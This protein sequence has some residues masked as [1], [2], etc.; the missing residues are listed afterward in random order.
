[1]GL[2]SSCMQQKSIVASLDL[3]VD[4][5]SSND[6]LEDS[7]VITADIKDDVTKSYYPLLVIPVTSSTRLTSPSTNI[8]S[9]LS[10]NSTTPYLSASSLNIPRERSLSARSLSSS[11]DRTMSH[12]SWNNLASDGL[13]ML[14]DRTR[15]DICIQTLDALKACGVHTHN[16]VTHG[17][18]TPLMIAVLKGDLEKV[19]K[20]FEIGM[21]VNKANA[22]GETPLSLAK[23]LDSQDIYNFLKSK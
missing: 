17:D 14:K 2:L 19:K 15:E 13:E 8:V 22:S 5:S 3:T 12:F 23:E 20:Y 9:F 6:S 7:D 16:F 10:A 18:R 4:Y 1:M 21:D 11:T